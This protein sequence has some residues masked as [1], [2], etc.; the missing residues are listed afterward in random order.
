LLLL[1]SLQHF[2]EANEWEMSV[3]FCLRIHSEFHMEM[4]HS[5]SQY[6]SDERAVPTE[7]LQYRHSVSI[8]D[9]RKHSCLGAE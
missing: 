7:N 3:L 6:I 4:F 8:K 2:A 1:F 5:D 9:W